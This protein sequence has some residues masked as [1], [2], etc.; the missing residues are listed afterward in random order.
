MHPVV[1]IVGRPNVGKSSL[2]NLLLNQRR[3]LVHEEAGTTRDRIEARCS[4][5]ENTCTLVDTGG[6]LHKDEDAILRQVLVQVKH[7]MAESDVLLLVVDAKAGLVPMDLEVAGLLRKFSKLVCLV[8]NKADNPTLEQS[9]VDF[10]PLSLGDPIPVSCTQGTGISALRDRLSQLLQGSVPET[11]EEVSIRMAVVG[12]PNVGKSSFLN[13][14]LNH[15]RLVV[16]AAPGTTRDPV[17]ILFKK[18]DQTYILIDT[19]GIRRFSKI[20]DAILFQS[21]RTTREMIRRSDICLLLI[22]G[23]AGVL[24][25]DLQI[26]RW[27]A[28]EGRGVVLLVNKWDLVKEVKEKDAETL[29]RRRLGNLNFM[30]VLF[31]SAVTGR[32][33][34]ESVALAEEV[35]KNYSGRIETHRLNTLLS[36]IRKRPELFPGRHIPHVTYLVQT[37]TRPPQFLVFGAS[38][39]D[40]HSD[41]LRFLERKLRERFPLS[42]A[43]V[44]FTLRTQK[45]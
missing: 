12:R 42:G 26:L 24:E 22:D 44:K 30:P 28:E 35:S 34:L 14:L 25:E 7:A 13:K 6:L 9:A 36:E 16:D 20:R 39:E 4:L 10:Y 2:F 15:E 32:N 3:S 40:L 27:I 17:D 29:L 23:A 18:G 19:A 43:P 21:V 8:A 33:V 11:A 5:G 37:Q 1:A 31:T 45:R 41:F 38:R